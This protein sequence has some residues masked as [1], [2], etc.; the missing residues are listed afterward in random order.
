MCRGKS[1]EKAD[2]LVDI[3]IGEHLVKKEK[4]KIVTEPSK[5]TENREIG[6]FGIELHVPLGIPSMPSGLHLLGEKEENEVISFL[7]P[8]LVTSIKYLIYFSEIFPKKYMKNF[9]PMTPVVILSKR[10]KNIESD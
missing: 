7:N 3:I 10:G 8:R 6:A 1:D 2:I 5:E 4:P 9:L